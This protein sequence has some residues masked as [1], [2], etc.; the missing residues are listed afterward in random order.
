MARLYHQSQSLVLCR[1]HQ[2]S[3]YGYQGWMK[4]VTRMGEFRTP[5]WLMYGE[6]QAGNKNQS[7]PNL[8]WIDTVKANVQWLHIQLKI[9]GTTTTDSLKWRVSATNPDNAQCQKITAH[10]CEEKKASRS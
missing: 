9:L 1:L 3:I 5:R 2:H 4:H 8:R 7:R 6:L 10:C